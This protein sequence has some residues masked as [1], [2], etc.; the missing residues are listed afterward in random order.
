MINKLCTG[1]YLIF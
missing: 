1:K